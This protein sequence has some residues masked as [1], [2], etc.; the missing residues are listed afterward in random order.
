M[1]VYD[2]DVFKPRQQQIW[3]GASKPLVDPEGV[4]R[5]SADNLQGV[6]VAVPEHKHLDAEVERARIVR[7][8]QDYDYV[9]VDSPPLLHVAETV[10]LAARSDGLV[11][12]VGDTTPLVSVE[13][14]VR[15][16]ERLGTRLVGFVLNR[17]R[18]RQIP[19]YDAYLTSE[20]SIS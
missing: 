1:L 15:E 12:V 20:S 16:A 4:R 10:A 17:V 13:R 18:E 14:A 3:G 6:A 11:L 19:Q 5:L 8:A 9:L 2:A 7:L